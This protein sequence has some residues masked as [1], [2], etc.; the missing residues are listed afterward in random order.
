MI[1]CAGCGKQLHE[2]ARACPHCGKPQ[3]VA[4]HAA[5]IVGV[6]TPSGPL[7][8]AITSLVLGVICAL[9]LLDD[10]EWDEDTVY[11]LILF[12]IIGLV[13]GI[14]GLNI[15]KRGRGMAVAGIVTSAVGFLCGLGLLEGT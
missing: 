10:S 2:T 13:F 12:S 15:G 5:G 9:A 14:V 1:F 11:G 6:A 8:A 3:A 7:W 4:A